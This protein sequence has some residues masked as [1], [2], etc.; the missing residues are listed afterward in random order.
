MKNF[1]SLVSAGIIG[2]LIVFGGMQLDSS[3]NDNQRVYNQSPSATL[4]S[5]TKT[6]VD[7]PF[8]F[9]RASEHATEVV[10]HIVAEES[11]ESARK[12]TENR[13]KNRRSPF[14]DFF[15]GDFF[16]NDFFGQDF[17]R[18]GNAYP[19][20]GSGS[21][22]IFSKDG[23][24]VTNNHVVGFAD[25]IL[26]TLEDGREVKATKIGTDPTTDLAVIKIDVDNN[27]P[28]LDFANSDEVR[29]GEWVLAVGNPFSY[30]T[31]TVTAGIVSAKGRDL[32]IISEDKSIEE[33]IQTD[34]AVN[35]GNSGGALVNTEGKL[36]GINTAIATPTGVYAGYSFAIP[37]NLVKRIVYDIIENGDIERVNLGV[38]GYDVDQEVKEEFKLN[39]DTGFY[40]DS[41]DKGS[42]AQFSGMLPGDV[43]VEINEEK[44]ERFEDIV[45]VMKY[46]KA[47]DTVKIEIQRNGKNKKLD[48]RLRKGL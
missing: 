13:R 29:V 45:E 39:T 27:L 15:G 32:D 21:G 20:N 41:I 19:K 30:L 14:D 38:L 2:G 44:I 9:V 43:I 18:G 5:S 46:N 22:V 11:M 36:V 1:L 26:V 35:P 34:A 37:S 28:T 6:T 33:F 24:I 7:E 47:G 42:A 8:D 25:N 23:Y 17:F 10:V 48:V 16:G 31:S 3:Y 40:V 4:V 12:R